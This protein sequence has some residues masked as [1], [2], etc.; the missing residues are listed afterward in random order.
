MADWLLDPPK[1]TGVLHDMLGCKVG[2]FP[3]E[4]PFPGIVEYHERLYFMDYRNGTEV[5]YSET[6]VF[7]IE[8]LEP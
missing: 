2:T 8:K 5:A 4:M 6:S 3:L 7:E 1:Y